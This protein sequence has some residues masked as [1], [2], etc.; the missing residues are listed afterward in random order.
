M[1]PLV[2]ALKLSLLSTKNFVIGRIP[3]KEALPD[4]SCSGFPFISLNSSFGIVCSDTN[5]LNRLL[6]LQSVYIPHFLL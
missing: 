2:L 4:R 5:S 6:W 1:S 3:V